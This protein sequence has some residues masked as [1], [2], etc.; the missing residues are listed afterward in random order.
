MIIIVFVMVVGFWWVV[1]NCSLCS[2]F[3]LLLVVWNWLFVVCC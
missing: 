3:V 2:S 1:W